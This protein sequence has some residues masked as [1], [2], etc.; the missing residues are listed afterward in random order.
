LKDGIVV[1]ILIKNLQN[2]RSNKKRMKIKY[3]R[4]KL[5]KDEI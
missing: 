2:N 5:D 1:K 4:K 3:D